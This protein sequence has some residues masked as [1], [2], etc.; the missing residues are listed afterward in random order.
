[1]SLDRRSAA[2]PSRSPFP[3]IRAAIRALG[4]PG[5][6]LFAA[7][8]AIE[9][10]A[11]ALLAPV[12]PLEALRHFQSPRNVSLAVTAIGVAGILAS[13]AL[14]ALIRL[15]APRRTY[16]AAIAA[17]GIASLAMLTG[18]L[19]GFVL[20]WA[21]RAM[22]AAALLGLLNLYIATFID[23]ARLSTAEPLRT[24]VS[25][26][27]WVSGPFFGAYLYGIADWIPFAL[28][29][30]V[31]GLLLIYFRWLRLEAT[32]PIAARSERRNPIAHLRRYWEQPRL[33]LAWLLNFG[34]ETWWVAFFTYGPIYLAGQGW[35]GEAIGRAI[36]SCTA[37]LFLT[38]AFGWL[39]RRL[40]LRRF[41]V[42]AF[43]WIAATTALVAFV[44]DRPE[45]AVFGLFAGAFGAVALD[46]TVVVTFLRAVRPRERAQMAMVFSTYRD[47]AATLP[48]ALF[49]GLLSFLP[50]GAVFLAVTGLSLLCAGLALYL[51]KRL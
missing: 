12:I 5:P 41:I 6:A 7:L 36:S 1:M 17:L 22:A 40:G 3:A 2:S 50:L 46:A 47:A 48:P 33:R 23:K 8:F 28:S 14:P 51:P 34:R 25:A 38:L 15:L 35:S 37:L 13:L 32:Q 19:F 44:L 10:F 39:G 18:S 16:L 9:S 20:G 30:L 42:G 4:S 11:R 24:F 43:L 27:A 31:A 45:I 21:L 49:A 29:A 26:T